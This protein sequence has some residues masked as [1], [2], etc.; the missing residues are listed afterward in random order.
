MFGDPLGSPAIEMRSGDPLATLNPTLFLKRL[1]SHAGFAPAAPRT[2]DSSDRLEQQTEENFAVALENMSRADMMTAM[3]G[4][5]SSLKQYRSLLSESHSMASFTAS[6]DKTETMVRIVQRLRMLL[7]AEH[8]SIFT[9]EKDGKMLSCAATTKPVSLPSDAWRLTVGLGFSGWAIQSAE[10]VNIRANAHEDRRYSS[11]MAARLGCDVSTALCV[12]VFNKSRQIVGVIE[13][14]NKVVSPRSKKYFSSH[15][16]SMAE[17]LSVLAGHAIDNAKLL[18]EAVQRRRQTETLLQVTELMAAEMDTDRVIRRM[19]EACYMLVSAERL[20]L[21]VLDEERDRL[22]AKAGKDVEDEFSVPLT[23][24]IVGYVA[25]TGKTVNA[26]VASRDWRFD[27][28]ADQRRGLSHYSL[29]AVPVNDHLGKTVGVIEAINLNLGAKAGPSSFSAS[30]SAS[31]HAGRAG[32]G[33]G[34]DAGRV[35][36]LDAIVGFSKDEE[37]LLQN[38]AVSAGIILRKAQ[39]FDEAV[40]RK[41]ETESLLQI[42]ELMT[43]DTGMSKIIAKIVSAAYTL[44]GAERVFWYTVD[45]RENEL[46]VDSVKDQLEGFRVPLGQGVA[47]HAALTGRAV[48]IANAE[49]PDWR[50]EADSSPLVGPAPSPLADPSDSSALEAKLR[51]K[52]KTIL[53]VPVVDALGKTIAVIEALNKKARTGAVIPFTTDDEAMLKSLGVTAA[54]VL[55]K[56]KLFDEAVKH[57]QQTAALLQISEIM[58]AEIASEKIMQR[59]IEASYALVNADRI[60]LFTVDPLTKE[61]VCQVSKDPLVV[62][63]RMPLGHGIVGHVASSR[64]SL[65]IPNAYSDPRFDPR[66]DM[67]TGYRTQSILTVPVIDR[68]GTT[69]A[70]LQAVNKRGGGGRFG[71]E[72]VALLEA[73]ALNAGL[74]YEKSRLLE[75]AVDAARR[76]QAL[77][78]LVKSAAK[79]GTLEEVIQGISSAAYTALNCER[80]TV[81]FV[82]HAKDE[83]YCVVCKDVAGWT[84]PMGTGIA[85]YV[86]QSGKLVNVENAYEDSR[87]D[88]S[89]DRKSSFVTHSVLCMP[90]KDRDNQVIAVIQALNKRKPTPED[91]RTLHE[92]RRL[93]RSLRSGESLPTLSRV[94]SSQHSDSTAMA[95]TSPKAPEGL[96]RT[97]SLDLTAADLQNSKLQE[98][99]SFTHEDEQLLEAIAHETSSVLRRYR[100]DALLE[101]SELKGRD[102]SLCSLVDMC[103]G[104]QSTLPG[105]ATS[106]FQQVFQ[107]PS[108]EKSKIAP[109]LNS[110]DFN[111]FS[112]DPDQLLV[113]AYTIFEEL[114]LLN[115]FQIPP[116]NLKSFLLQIRRKYRDN[117]FHNWY[118]GFSVLHFAYLAIRNLSNAGSYLTQQDVLAL[119]VASMCHD[120]DHPGWTNS[121]EINTGS[122]LALVHNDIS[123]LESHHAYTTFTVLR[124]ASA[125]IFVNLRRDTFRSVKTAIVG[126]ILATDMSHHFD[127][128]RRLDAREVDSPYNSKVEA[129]RQ[130]VINVLVHSADLSGQVFPTAVAKVWE[131]RI[132]REFETQAV[133]E[134][135][136]GLPVA[137]FMVGLSDPVVRAQAQ[138]NFIDFVLVPWWRSVVRIF[139]GM[140]HCFEQLMVNRKYYHG[141]VTGG[142]PVEN[143]KDTKANPAPAQAAAPAAAAAPA[144]SP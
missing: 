73:M 40:R 59:M 81:Y 63:A 60:T 120:V 87:F 127:E 75:A 96:P 113:F 119:L 114:D 56:A 136:Q 69:V 20:T 52:A 7:D 85:G 27:P 80:L 118:H 101:L 13:V 24:G 18:E 30:A 88:P 137:P 95:P 47:G 91:D 14:A 38:I 66:T 61:I 21:F 100:S 125:N 128:I 98:I 94:P 37:M 84:L 92:R 39:L 25:T 62:G 68:S 71:P 135:S 4:M 106:T 124:M 43:A 90:V 109:A 48:N 144:S 23:R 107:W 41:K 8:A 64:R 36:S 11:E 134:K 6:A 57:R 17:F 89:W 1:T 53:A 104:T 29:L 108:F 16:Q 50:F 82:D 126:A 83:L 70:V 112:V 121:Y 3:R 132:A 78:S 10:T 103:R 32:A 133:R 77:L 58:S 110:L 123:V 65:N 141:F 51:I 76:N 72:D 116:E 9:I 26:P 115:L 122:E 22:V 74:L 99:V 5:F 19:L 140:R 35:V 42:T 131:E 93:R 105:A 143:D 111:V 34:A 28:K 15:D 130:H 2:D 142:K 86:A 139:P 54:T 129:D 67:A 138:V 55:R 44:V 46:V 97:G 117:P 102:A 33:A 49:A 79:D 12:P 45:E 31:G